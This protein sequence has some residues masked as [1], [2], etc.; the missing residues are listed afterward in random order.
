[1]AGP[2]ATMKS[3]LSDSR[4]KKGERLCVRCLFSRRS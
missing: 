1:L 3:T 2:D 4:Q